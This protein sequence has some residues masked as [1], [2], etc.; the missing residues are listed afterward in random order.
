[1]AFWRAHWQCLAST[2]VL[3]RAGRHEKGSMS[4]PVNAVS[5][6]FWKDEALERTEPDFKH[7]ATGYLTH[8]CAA[9]FWTMLYA[10]WCHKR[11]E[12]LTPKGIVLGAL[13]TSAVAN[14]ADYKL[15][16][17]RLMPGYEHHLSKT[18]L[19]GVYLAFAAGVA[20]GTYAM[21]QK[22]REVEPPEP[23]ESVL[24]QPVH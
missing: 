15:T 23:A 18:A 2:A 5:H 14:F 17:K 1:M 21:R 8:H 22:Y 16:P 11:P 24:R 10:A 6:W 9:T 13:A 12:T 19:L 20:A 7:T 3:L 4:A